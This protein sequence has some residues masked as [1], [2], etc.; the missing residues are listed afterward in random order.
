ML[1]MQIGFLRYDGKTMFRKIIKQEIAKI[2]P[3]GA[4][5]FVDVPEQVEHGDYS[6]NVALILAKHLKR[7]PK[8]VAE[9]LLAKLMRPLSNCVERIEVA[10]PGFLNFYL[11]TSALY[12]AL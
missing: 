4:K 5:F 3:P 9:D 11:K 12:K 8:E 10:G 2:V 1:L 7:N 6:S